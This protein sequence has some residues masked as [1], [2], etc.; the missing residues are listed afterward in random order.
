[1]PPSSAIRVLLVEDN[2]GDA[3]L[4]CELL[5]EA[6]EPRIEVCH[7]DCLND[8]LDRIGAES[9]DA[10]LLD[11]TLRDASGLDTVARV[12]QRA[13]H[14]PII[15]LSGLNDEQTAVDALANGA[16]DYL[17]KGQ[18]DGF[19][20]SRAVRYAIERKRT[21]QQLYDAKERA[22]F[23]NRAKSQ[24]L[25]NMS[26]ELR[27]PLNAI[28]GFSEIIKDD[29]LGSAGN[30]TYKEYAQHIHESGTHLL[31]IINDILD[32]SRIEAGKLD[33]NESIIDVPAAIDS[34]L[35]IV[36]DR[37]EKAKV[38]ITREAPETLPPLWAD[39][40]MLKQ[41]LLN[42]L[43]NAVKFTPAGGQITV[44]AALD[45]EGALLL[46]VVDTGIGIAE[47][48]LVRAMT[49]FVQVE[50]TLN[51]RFPGTGLGLPLTK[52]LVELHGGAFSLKSELGVG[53]TVC[54]RFSAER[55][56]PPDVERKA[57]AGG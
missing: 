38:T 44:T 47:P 53:T 4:T 11:L 7:V 54:V 27:T 40:R 37:A 26:H 29:A 51:R 6:G 25:A 9:F 48:D 50:N 56:L 39:E 30:Q 45:D 28:I 1:M 46:T 20:I 23:A 55:L 16:Q 57:Q 41:I 17:V 49:P 2:Q 21:L 35:G 13:P 42:I 31:A 3:R 34:C 52:S 36:R 12:L 32:L 18:G 22:E 24:F 43:S 8:A 15:V 10:V 33:L 19:L 14:L 5:S